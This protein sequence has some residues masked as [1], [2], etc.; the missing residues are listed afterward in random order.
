[1]EQLTLDI[2]KIEDTF[3]GN[4]QLLG[5]QTTLSAT[6]LCWLLEHNLGLC[7]QRKM[8]DD[9]DVRRIYDIPKAPQLSGTL[10]D[11]IDTPEEPMHF[12]VYRHVFNHTDS[13]ILLYANHRNGY[14]LLPESRNQNFLLLIQDEDFC[15]MEKSLPEWLTHIPAIEQV[16]HL[17]LDKIKNKANLII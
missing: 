6:R 10:F 1:M 4:C 5:I 15:I 8:M 12:S 13:G 3:F 9:I 2:G 16:N 11:D 17:H 14:Y 7:F